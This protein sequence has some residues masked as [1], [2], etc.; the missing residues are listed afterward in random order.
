MKKLTLLGILLLGLTH[1][2][3]Q[4]FNEE[5]KRL[6]LQAE[7]KNDT[8]ALYQLQQ[9]QV[10][11]DIQS[12]RFSY[13]P[14]LAFTGTYTRLNDDIVFP[15]NLQSLL[16]GTQVLLIKESLGMGFNATL[17]GGV[18]LQSV[19][20]IQSKNILKGNLNGQWLLFSGFKVSNGVKAYQHQQQVYTH[21]TAKQKTKLW[22]DIADVYDKMALVHQADAIISSSEKI[23]NEQTRFVNAAIDNGLATPLDRKRVALAQQKLEVKRQEN[24]TNLIVLKHKMHQLTGVADE[25]LDVLQP[26]LIPAPYLRQTSAEE[27]PEIKALN[28]GIE[29]THYLEKAAWSD[30]VPKLAAFGQYELRENDLSLLDPVWYAGVRLQ[31]NFFDGLSAR[32]NARKASLQREQLVVQKKAAMDMIQLGKDKYSEDFE[33]ATQKMALKDAET[34]LAKDTYD[35]VD[36]QY[37]NGLAPLTEVLDALNDVEKASFEYQQAL[38]EQRK[39]GLKAADLNGYLLANL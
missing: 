31:W 1:A 29:A 13:L 15:Q 27:R 9:Q 30:Y 23:L 6:Y 33:L 10:A 24:K 36:K 25:E 16:M 18:P 35:F 14:K 28:E 3:A 7:A 20:A 19:D 4:F 38:Y 2:H 22:L 37:R 11:T 12:A 8:L 17:P 32:N 5:T 39:A 26:E 21:L 34:K